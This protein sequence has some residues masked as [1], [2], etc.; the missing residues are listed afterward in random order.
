MKPLSNR[1]QMGLTLLAAHTTLKDRIVPTLGSFAQGVWRAFV[2][3]RTRASLSRPQRC[4]LD[5]M[6]AIQRHYA[7]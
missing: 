3:K 6:R 5:Q 1:D 4:A 7:P 2:G